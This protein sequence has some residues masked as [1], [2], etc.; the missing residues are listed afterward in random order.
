M[1]DSSTSARTFQFKVKVKL[2]R[3]G[4]RRSVGSRSR[5]AAPGRIRILY[6]QGFQDGQEKAQYEVRTLEPGAH[7]ADCDCTPCLTVAVVL[8]RWAHGEV[9]YCYC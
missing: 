5:A 9:R 4:R 2:S 1:A 3:D 8:V 7:G 6:L